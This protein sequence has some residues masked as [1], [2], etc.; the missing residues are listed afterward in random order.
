M[1]NYPY[2]PLNTPLDLNNLSKANENLQK[3]EADISSADSASQQRD[4][5]LQSTITVGLSSQKS[6]YTRK[7]EE[8]NKKLDNVID[9]VSNQALEQVVEKAT[10]NRSFAPVDTFADLETVYPDAQEGDAVQT[11]DDNKV[12]R[13]NGTEWVFIEQFGVG[14]FTDVY[15]QLNEIQSNS[16]KSDLILM[17]VRESIANRS[18]HFLVSTNGVDFKN[19]SAKAF[20]PDC[21]DPSIMYKDGFF[22]VAHSDYPVGST[23][24][25][26]I[27]RSQN[28]T[29]W[30]Q[31]NISVGFR[32][33]GMVTVWS[34]EW[35]EDDDGK[36][37]ITI[38]A[39]PVGPSDMRNYISEVTNLTNLTVSPARLLGI[40]TVENSNKID[41]FIYKVGSVYKLLIKDENNRKI[42]VWSSSNLV[43]WTKELDSITAFDI[44]PAI[45]SASDNYVEG[46]HVVDFNGSTLVYADYYVRGHFGV[47]ESNASLTTFSNGKPIRT[48]QLHRHGTPYVVRDA[49]AK[50]IVTNYISSNRAV[51]ENDVFKVFGLNGL[52]TSANVIADLKPQESVVYQ[53]NGNENITIN[54]VSFAYGSKKFYLTFGA[55]SIG[56]I[57]LK[58]AGALELY[59][60]ELVLTG[61]EN[62][63]TIHE[64]VYSEDVGKYRLKNY[65]TRRSTSGRVDL[66]T[67]ATA[68]TISSLVPKD[69]FVY[70]ALGSE[71]IT[72]NGVGSSS[73]ARRFFLLVGSTGDCSITIPST[74]TRIGTP[75]NG[76]TI[77][78]L[79][80]DSNILFEFLY[81][82][83]AGTY[84]MVGQ[85]SY[86]VLTSPKRVKTG[87]TAPTVGADFIGQ[88]YLNTT[89]ST[90]YFAKTATV[91]SPSDW[92]TLN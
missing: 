58:N 19:V 31:F 18:A 4:A 6:E 80:G 15:D 66:S 65:P 34:P 44:F 35:F 12:Y 9:E 81:D 84:R 90:V 61:G 75:A 27:S 50:D 51:L 14:P 63:I 32:S 2:D 37:Y 73:K 23:W 26:K 33:S 38:S 56:S 85:T 60:D 62:S 49:K 89:T 59:D 70:R 88:H 22:Y 69:G 82:S 86:N 28:L 42:E 20:L 76:I 41:P 79:Y 77:S 68:G 52:T 57:T 45:V 53:L 17:P 24:D 13:F 21:A 74:A 36:I 92:I 46:A 25:F 7:I 67:L 1:P 40:E 11:L 47:V 43:A 5:A 16:Y 72:I 55:A 29:D 3:I 87:T 8:Q 83:I 30:E 91:T 64:F 78:G 10:V 48:T 71:K 39:S 54:S